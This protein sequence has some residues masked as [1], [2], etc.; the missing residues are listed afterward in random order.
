MKLELSPE[1]R[2]V[3]EKIVAAALQELRVEVRR[4]TTPK[5]HDD[6][7]EEE[8]RVEGLLERIKTLPR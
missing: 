3:L 2:T 5:Y 1:D 6:M 4:T 7:R 8:D